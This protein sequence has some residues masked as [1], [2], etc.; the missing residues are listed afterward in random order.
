MRI[1]HALLSHWEKPIFMLCKTLRAALIL[2][3]C[4]FFLP[5]P[6][7]CQ[8]PSPAIDN[9]EDRISSMLSR[10]SLE[11]KID[12]LGG[13]DGMYIRSEPA[14]GMPPL[15]MSDGPVG[16]RTWGPS[17]AFAAGIAL[18]ATWDPKLANRVGVSLGQDARARGVHFLLGPGVNVYR[19]PANGRN[20]EYFGEDPYLASRMAVSYVRGVQSQG[21]VA[22]VKHFALNNQEWDR[23]NVSSDATERTMREIYFPAF[24]AA[25]REGHAGAVM[26]SYNLINGVHATENFWMNNQVLKRDWKFDGILMSDWGSTYDGVA[27]A[28]GGL[29]LEMPRGE[30][31]NRASL[32]PAIGDGRLSEATIDD[33]V[34]RILR[35]S[36]R[37]HFLD[38]PQE[39]L[40]ISRYNQSA[41]QVALDEAR[42]SIVLLKNDGHLL[43]LDTRKIHTIALI[44]PEIWPIVTGGGGSSTVTPFQSV[45][46]LQSLS[47]IPGLNVLYSPGIPTLAQ[48]FGDTKFSDAVSVEAF[49]TADFTG[50]STT[51]QQERLNDWKVGDWVP[52]GEAHSFRYTTTFLP[53][54]TGA[55]LFVSTAAGE[56]SYTVYVDSKPLL[57]QARS[58]GQAP[59][60]AEVRL[61]AGKTVSLRVD[62]VLR[63]SRPRFGLA[64]RASDEVVSPDVQKIAAL[65]DIVVV[66]VGFDPWNE[67][68]GYDRSFDLPFGQEPMIHAVRAANKNVIAVLTAGGEVATGAWLG[69]IPVLLD[70]WYPG[71]EGGD[72]LAEILTGARS[73]EGKLPITFVGSWEQNP[74]HDTY[75][76]DPVPS[77]QF[78]H[79]NY[80]EGV[81]FGYRYFTTE[82]K[83]P[84]Y[85]FGFGLSYT[86]FSFR[87]LHVSDPPAGGPDIAVSFE[88]TNTGRVSGADVAQLYVGDPSSKVKRPAKELKAFEKVRLDPGEKKI[89][90]FNLDLRALSY[91]DE[92]A[93]C[94]RADAGTFQ[95]FVGD[96]SQ[97]TPLTA[98]FSYQPR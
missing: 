17:T 14:L 95:V 88:V 46:L 63:A 5:F 38:R 86:T 78:A 13:S 92:S 43:P 40:A 2:L 20:F 80:K 64:V 3:L 15:K 68:E 39:D 66:S 33:K 87:D 18:A 61:S 81:F 67:S 31:M 9:E 82:M 22:T 58:E 93:H 73:P 55:Y 56:D 23:H 70:N 98:N 57:H 83:K 16:V 54:T 53:P 49:A 84:L 45:S 7:A 77:G 30:F 65:S 19:A 37:F 25:V 35:I 51:S 90:T 6:V 26:N 10:L 28:N 34:R 44:G 89:V 21:V 27:A 52:P 4:R 69:D 32:L 11:E 76:A 48:L 94:W 41:R 62:Y 75:Y 36:S 72:A 42:E 47:R 59:H 1:R 79:L 29:D 60:S 91:W 71:Q 12:L 97:D 74:V 8:E 50:A 85:P 96:S 24:E